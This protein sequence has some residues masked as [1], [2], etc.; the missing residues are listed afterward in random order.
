M[1]KNA[2]VLL[3]LLA[4]G[5]CMVS[6]SEDGSDI[7]DNIDNPCLRI[8][9]TDNEQSI[10]VSN[11]SF[12]FKLFKSANDN[13]KNNEQFVISPLSASMS[14]SMLLNGT[15]NETLASS[16]NELGLQGYTLDEL[17][18][19]NAKLMDSLNTL[20]KKT[21]IEF[22]NSMWLNEGLD[23]LPSFTSAVK[24]NYMAAVVN[25]DF[26]DN[27]TL[28]AINRWCS[29]ATKGNI[30]NLLE[31]MPTPPMLLVNALYFKGLWPEPL[32][33]EK[34]GSFTTVTGEE[35]TV[36]YMSTTVKY[37]LLNNGK[38][39][40]T[41][42]SYGN[43]AFGFYI[44][45]PDEGVSVDECINDLADE[46]WL[47]KIENN[48]PAEVAV[49]MPKFEVSSKNSL[50]PSLKSAGLNSCFAPDADYSNLFSSTAYSVSEV[51]QATTIK[52]DEKGTQAAS[53]TVV[54]GD[55]SPGPLPT[56]ELV[57]D[58]PFIFFINESSTGAI[59]FVGKVG[60][61]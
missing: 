14:L 42:L 53:A 50:L 56:Y 49:K 24:E 47:D 3:S 35:Q 59:L 29:N 13:F 17:N 8:E 55:T 44:I 43:G 52:V 39:K 26:L 18:G 31:T 37:G 46:Y 23:A 11:A 61:I 60:K 33:N 12:S 51:L 16:L 4:L 19:I 20:D 41:R 48:S 58:R 1:K 57:V 34:E 40:G 54:G 22:A 7:P 38:C 45:L 9:L 21:T 32:K 28:D 27:A 5:A 2:F 25:K 36:E 15:A 10:M 30:N 6:C